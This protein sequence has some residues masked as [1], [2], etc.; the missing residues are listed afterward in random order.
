[1]KNKVLKIMISLCVI[2][3]FI[4]LSVLMVS[5]QLVKS[6]KTSSPTQFISSETPDMLIFL[7]PQY[8]HDSDIL[9]AV[10]TYINA[11]KEDIDWNA[12]IIKISEEN[13]DYQIIDEIIEDL[14]GAN[15]RGGKEIKPRAIKGW[16][17]Q[18]P[19]KISSLVE[20]SL[21]MTNGGSLKDVEVE[22]KL[23]ELLGLSPRKTT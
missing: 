17:K 16:L 1:M 18:T 4:G 8:N 2:L 11:V 15:W 9:S 10:K 3:L 20:K 23:D 13:N 19:K 21:I 7:S 12:N 6:E 5:A 22:K 14:I